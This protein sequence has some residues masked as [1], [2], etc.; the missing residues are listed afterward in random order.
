MRDQHVLEL[1]EIL[2]ALGVSVSFTDE[3]PDDRDGDYDHATRTIWLRASLTERP[4][5]ASLAHETA[6]AVFE[7]VKT[8][9]GPINRRQERRADEWAALFLI[10]MD[11]YR[12]AEA[13]HDGNSEAIAL[14]LNVTADLVE[15]F[16]SLLLRLGD[17]VYVGPRMGAGQ[18]HYRIEAAS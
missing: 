1:Y 2:E 6:H 17:I 16:Q 5:R 4:Y 15:V 13:E 3:L 11:A 18:W 14:T 8:M 10:D 12:S 9:F 7:D